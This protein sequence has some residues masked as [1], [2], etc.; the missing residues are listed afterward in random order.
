MG[1]W[2]CVLLHPEGADPG[3]PR[4]GVTLETREWAPV[5]RCLGQSS[6]PTQ[7]RSMQGLALLDHPELEGLSRLCR[8]LDLA[9]LAKVR[10]RSKIKTSRHAVHK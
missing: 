10:R 2:L 1:A 3:S 8:T 4:E 6:T 9:T 5:S 7:L